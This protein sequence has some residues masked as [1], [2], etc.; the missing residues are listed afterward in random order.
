[1]LAEPVSGPVSGRVGGDELS[2]S[3][4]RTEKERVGKR[5]L[6]R[7]KII[8]FGGQGNRVKGLIAPK[9]ITPAKAGVMGLGRSP[10]GPVSRRGGACL[11]ANFASWLSACARSGL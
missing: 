6:C 7:G 11:R 4:Y 2:I 1:M 5:F 8:P 10:D 9:I 3:E